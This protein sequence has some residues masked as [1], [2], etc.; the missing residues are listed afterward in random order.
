MATEGAALSGDSL[1]SKSAFGAARQC[2]LQQIRELPSQLASYAP[3]PLA[4]PLAYYLSMFLMT[5]ALPLL[6]QGQERLVGATRPARQAGGLWP[7]TRSTPCSWTAASTRAAMAG[8][9]LVICC[10]GS[11]YEMGCL[12]RRSWRPATRC[13]A[14]TTRASGAA[15]AR[16]SLSMMPMPWTWLSSTRCRLLPAHTRGGLWLVCWR[17][18][19]HVGHHDVRSWAR[20]V[21]C[22]LRRSRAAGAEGH[23]HSWK[24]LVVR[25][26]R[27]H[28]NLNVR[29]SNCVRYPGPVLLLRRTQDDVVSTSGHLRPL[30]GRASWRAQPRQ[31]R[32]LLRLLRTATP[33]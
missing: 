25:T 15:R 18:H 9:R 11:G 30:P 1:D 8:L 14:G 32:L 21:A 29:R 5:R 6:Q 26:V 28:F 4:G 10:E 12:S 20:L 2:L 3:A 27:E 7:A 16:R 19:G 33:L 22:H 31:Q 17:L 23:A 24:G 13:W